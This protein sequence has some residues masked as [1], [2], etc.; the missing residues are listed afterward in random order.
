MICGQVP[1]GRAV[2]GAFLLLSA[3]AS[4]PVALVRLPPILDYPNHLARMHILAALPGSP[5]LARW[6]DAAWAPLPNLALDLIVPWIARLMPV[7]V[8]MRLSLAAILIALAGGCLALHRVVFAR[9]SMFPL[10]G[11]LLLYNRMLLW[12]FLNYLA[13]LALM[14]WA[15]AAWI[16]LKKH[17][18]WLR[19]LVGILAATALYFA[20]LAAFGCYGL[21][22]VAY[23]FSS[24][25]PRKR[26]SLLQQR[27]DGQM[28]SRFRGNDNGKM[29]PL[30]AIASLVPG[31]L[32]FVFSPT[33]SV[34]T[35]IAYGNIL[36]KLDLPVS[37]FDNYSR[38]FDGL[39]FAIVLIAVV[40]GLI[41][42]AI[43]V[44]PSL[45][46]SLLLLLAAYVAVPSRLL[47]ASGLDHRLPIAIAFM[48]V[49]STD[50]SQI[51]RK[52]RLLVASGAL[53][54]FL[55]RLA[56]LS[57]IWMKADKLYAELIPA[58]DLV[59]KGGALAI[60]APVG[61]TQAGGIPLLH[62]P[63]L[64]A[65]RRDAFVPTIF[66]DPAQQPIRLTHIAEEL[67][68][69]AS[70]DRLWRGIKNRDLPP[71]PG[72]DVL[73]VIDP[74]QPMDRASLPGPILFDSP[75][76]ALI[77]LPEA[78]EFASQ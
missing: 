2:W 70:S 51:S 14:L 9:W 60:A 23:A 24:S 65:A 26:E 73:A 53:V 10:A 50:W 32:L 47:S 33:S 61:S 71:L 58:L 68:K 67:A 39:T 76:F 15:L 34:V 28:D 55:A 4:L 63:V 75:R 31:A 42:G 54:L 77:R 78:R 36:R 8:A 64:A 12:G 48:F 59:P 41:R 3:L 21:A 5:A 13:G 27:N 37:I 25:F 46:W 62:F 45:R 6:Y 40:Y 66:A 52:G 57:V 7:E 19:L 30:L 56:V 1:R 74:P 49:A 38:I 16:A 17:P 69:E 18:A 35:G 22:L 43:R 72:Y 44:Y 11:F 20:H 29:E